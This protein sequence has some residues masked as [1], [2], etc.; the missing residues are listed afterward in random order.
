MTIRRITIVLY[1]LAIALFLVVAGTAFVRVMLLDRFHVGGQSMEPTL[2]EGDPLWVEK[3]T[4]G[5][6]IYTRFDFSS[7]VLSCIRM[8]GFGHLTPGDIAVF[9]SP[10]GGESGSIGFRINYVFAKRCIGSPGDTIRIVN[11]F[12]CN[13]SMPGKLLCPPEGQVR[14]SEMTL[15][16][17][18]SAGVY[19]KTMNPRWSIR[20]FGPLLIPKKGSRVQFDS[21]SVSVYAKAVEY[22]SGRF[23]VEGETYTF[24]ENWY[25]FGGDQVLNSRD[26]RYIGLVPEPYIIGRVLPGFHRDRN[27]S[28]LQKG[29]RQLEAAL[30]FAQNN[31]GELEKVLLHY[32]R[33][34]RE[35][36]A[37]E[38]LVR[39]MPYHYSYVPNPVI[40][41]IKAVLRDIK[42][43]KDVPDE[44]KDRW[45]GFQ[46]ER[47]P[48]I[49]DSHVVT[50]SFLE[51]NIDQAFVAYDTRPWNKSVD[52]EEFC[53]LLLP[54]RVGT[55]P[56][57]P[58]RER[59]AA[60]YRHL[61]DS[62]YTGS[63]VVEAVDFINTYLKDSLFKYNVDFKA[64]SFGP[65]FLMDTRIGDCKES[66]EFTLYLLRALG[67]P[68]SMDFSNKGYIHTWN[69][70]LDTTGRREVFWFAH[71]TGTR[72]HR[73]GSDGRT[74]GKAYRRVFSPVKGRLYSDVTEEYFGPVSCQVPLE[75]KPKEG[76]WLGMFTGGRWLPLEEG[77]VQG[78]KVLFKDFEPGIVYAPVTRLGKE[79]GFPFIL[80]DHGILER[81]IPGQFADRVATSRKT[82]LPSRI[83]GFMAENAGGV[84][85]GALKEDFTD[86]VWADTLTSARINYNWLYPGKK[87]RFIRFR[88]AINHLLQLAEIRV[89]RDAERT[90]TVQLKIKAFSKPLEWRH[91]EG[92]LIDG[93]EL[94]FYYS[95]EK[96]PFVALDLGSEEMVSVIEWVPRN[97][98]NFIRYG[99]EYELLYNNGISGWCS[100]G[101]QLAKD[102]V[103]FWEGI[104]EHALLRLHDVTR[105]KEE[106]AFIVKDERQHF[107]SWGT[108]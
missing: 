20:D 68:V 13:S 108:L 21:L 53:E 33:N 55:E 10:E 71:H 31:R 101:A 87:M 24:R 40:D 45:K 64:P 5:A 4:L 106:D 2:H 58:W 100:L 15:E 35:Y 12:Y 47:L 49:Y 89:F 60:R 46:Y 67:I 72:I 103:L 51:G 84:M 17:L 93:D 8:P 18:D 11:G 44:R 92:L 37:A 19:W 29:D 1:R 25:F 22:E 91:R 27:A 80:H 3:W 105:G 9:N 83:V 7:P 75:K 73:G 65:D 43:G 82:R 99:D 48:R 52:F 54:Y 85:E 42:E 81:F 23:P 102:T 70:V 76:V 56:L 39:N 26:S 79:V 34:S 88:P 50:A 96:N 107:V 28:G 61:L 94:S 90:D 63:D 78:K 38:W 62:L 69:T 86:I 36:K 66:C 97:D 16:D 6:R 30:S 95:E 77:E 14:L 74:K 98:D 57:A 104:P 32:P 59:Y 41:S